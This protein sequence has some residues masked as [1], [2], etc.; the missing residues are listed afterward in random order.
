VP[1]NLPDIVF[2]FQFIFPISQKSRNLPVGL[3]L[4]HE[5]PFQLLWRG[6]TRH[7]F[8]LLDLAVEDV[9][10]K[11]E[12]LFSGESLLHVFGYFDLLRL[13]TVHFQTQNYRIW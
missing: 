1:I 4:D 2:S 11:N 9:V 8:F 3:A 13:G 5:H 7:V 12:D 10:G 6:E